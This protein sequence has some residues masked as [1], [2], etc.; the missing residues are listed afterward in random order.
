M[1][2]GIPTPLPMDSGVL[3]VLA[4]AQAGS[5]QSPAGALVLWGL[6]PQEP[7]DQPILSDDGAALP[8]SMDLATPGIWAGWKREE[9]GTTEDEMAGWHH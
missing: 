1:E 6:R 3:E 2:W 7:Q 9:K 8:P 5:G 4:H